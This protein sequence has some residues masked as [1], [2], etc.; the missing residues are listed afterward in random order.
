MLH[1]HLVQYA[2]K[3]VSTRCALRILGCARWPLLLNWCWECLPSFFLLFFSAPAHC[4]KGSYFT[5][6]LHWGQSNILHEVCWV[7]ITAESEGLHANCCQV[8]SR[9]SAVR[10]TFINVP[11]Y[12][13]YIWGSASA[14]W[15]DCWACWALP[16]FNN[17]MI[18]KPKET[19]YIK[20]I[21]SA[22]TSPK[23]NPPCPWAIILR[24][25]TSCTA[26]GSHCGEISRISR[27]WHRIW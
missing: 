8:K 1:A 15:V 2:Y 21:P 23:W 6:L 27:I 26:A 22:L 19:H 20:N 7:C 25:N 3:L 13:A 24:T 16:A 18:S 12:K 17:S 10:G 14:R 11:P 5:E 9:S 4:T